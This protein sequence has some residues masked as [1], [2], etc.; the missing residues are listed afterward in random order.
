MPKNE[1]EKEYDPLHM[2]KVDLLGYWTVHFK[3]SGELCCCSTIQPFC[4]PAV[5]AIYHPTQKDV[6]I[7]IDS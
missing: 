6:R 5:F 3:E 2:P 1:L 7:P 4:G